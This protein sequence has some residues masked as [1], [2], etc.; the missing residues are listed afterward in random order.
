[1]LNWPLWLG[2]AAAFVL[3]AL[4]FRFLFVP[5]RLVLKLLLNGLSG[6]IMLYIVNYAGAWF[7]FHIGV[8]PVTALTAGLLGIPGVVLLAGVKYLLAA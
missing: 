4:L 8:N 1:V 2:L 6:L 3:V 7:G 5:L